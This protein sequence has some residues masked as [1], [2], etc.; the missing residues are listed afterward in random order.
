M[1]Y[2]LPEYYT[3]FSAKICFQKTAGNFPLIA[4]EEIEKRSI[5]QR[6]TQT[7]R[8]TNEYLDRLADIEKKEDQTSVFKE[9]LHKYTAQQVQWIIR[10]ILKGT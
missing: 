4:F 7:V 8:Q 5:V 10:I 3:S 1:R 6:S 9:I 2:C